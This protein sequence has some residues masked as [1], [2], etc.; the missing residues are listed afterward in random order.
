MRQWVGV[1][2]FGLVAIFSLGVMVW[3]G[4]ILRAGLDPQQPF[5]TYTPPSAPDY[6]DPAAWALNEARAPNAG[7]VAVFFAAPTTYAGKREWNGPVDDGQSRAFLMRVVVPNQVGPFERV[8]PVSAPLY[9][10]GSLYSRLTL[11][12]DAREARAFAY[13]DIA[14]AFEVWIARHTQGPIVLV[15]VEQ[16]GE[17]LA[18]L[19]ADPAH[20]TPERR[21]RLLAVYLSDVI[22][23]VAQTPVPPCSSP[24]MTGCLVAFSAVDEGNEG[25][26][27]RRLRRAL[28]WDSHGRLIDL[29]AQAALCVNPVTGSVNVPR[30][31]ARDSRGATNATG[32]EWG[33]Q[34]AL[35]AREVA[36]ECRDGI[37]FHTRPNSEAYA[38]AG[39]WVERRLARPY[40]L[41]YG[42]LQHDVENRVDRYLQTTSN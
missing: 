13:Q 35:Q 3:S 20:M 24:D 21:Q 29:A 2:G 5:Q 25:A 7:H 34:P 4:D 1:L 10:Q 18:R 17:L 15:G 12:D 37:L 42:D 27:N 41:F 6:Q 26:A 32:L 36:A 14:Q 40:N 30:S 8:G 38:D 16:G 33:L 28:V 23:P 31:E 11:R 22:M 19:L 39:G 9:R